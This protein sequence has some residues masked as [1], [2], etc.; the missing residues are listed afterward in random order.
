MKGNPKPNWSQIT[1]RGST[2]A[3]IDPMLGMKFKII[4]KT[5]NINASSTPPI[6]STMP[7]KIPVTKEVKSLIEI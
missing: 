4:V 3:M 7:T 2:T 5:A 6:P 1:G